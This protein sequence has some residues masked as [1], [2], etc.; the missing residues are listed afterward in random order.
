MRL[1]H[2]SDGTRRGTSLRLFGLSALAV[3]VW[4][5]QAQPAT[6]APLFLNTGSPEFAEAVNRGQRLVQTFNRG[7]QLF[8]SNRLAEA[9]TEFEAVATNA[10]TEYRAVVTNA[11]TKPDV[12]ATNRSASSWI[13]SPP[14]LGWQ[15]EDMMGRIQQ[16]LGNLDKAAEHFAQA[17]KTHLTLQ[18]ANASV[19]DLIGE[20][21]LMDRLYHV[22]DV[23]GKLGLSSTA[24][25]RSE[26]LVQQ[27][28][29]RERAQP[30]D[31][32]VSSNAQRFLT[33]DPATPKPHPLWWNALWEVKS[34]R[35]A[36]RWRAGHFDEVEGLSKDTAAE[37]SALI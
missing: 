5:S 31:V 13:F 14:G 29:A 7:V 33:S 32:M 16:R 19:G 34:D 26:G 1:M 22:Y 10:Y 37:G 35:A 4:S 23:Q 6:N 18:P 15:A 11:Y 3:V 28:L 21:F 30:P 8:A 2:S 17:S 9:Y 12:V 36:L 25:T 24:Q 20:I 27:L